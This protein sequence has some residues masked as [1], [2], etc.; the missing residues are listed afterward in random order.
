MA[1]EFESHLAM[2]TADNMRTGMDAEEALRAA[3][4]KFGDMESVKQHYRD[5]ANWLTGEKLIQSICRGFRQLS[6]PESPREL[7][8]RGFED[9]RIVEETSEH[10]I[11]AIEEG[12]RA[13][14][15]EAAQREA[16]ERFRPPEVIAA[17]ICQEKEGSMN[18]L[19]SFLDTMWMRRW[20]ILVPSLLTAF[21]TVSTSYYFLPARDQRA[22]IRLMTTQG[23]PR[24]DQQLAASSQA[25]RGF[26][27]RE[28]MSASGIEEFIAQLGLAGSD[29]NVNILAHDPRGG[30]IRAEGTVRVNVEKH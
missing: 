24:E 5:T 2:H 25:A 27:I 29:I 3:R 16:L 19:K 7:S 10:L 23:V 28:R 14:S 21:V 12:R 4:L 9:A 22:G 1:E 6:T 13:L 17:D 30:G 15:I 8:A 18:H 20:W 26:Q 11:D